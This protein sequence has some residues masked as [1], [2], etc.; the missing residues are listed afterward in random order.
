MLSSGAAT[1]EPLK[2][3]LEFDFRVGRSYVYSVSSSRYVKAEI[4]QPVFWQTDRQISKVVRRTDEGSF[5]IQTNMEK[6]R[7]KRNVVI[8]YFRVKYPTFQTEITRDGR[9]KIPP[10]QPFPQVR[11]VPIFPAYAVGEGDKWV[12]EDVSFY[13]GGLTQEVNA[14]WEYELIE[15]VRHNGYSC[16]HIEAIGTVNFEN[17]PV[18]LAFLGFYPDPL[19]KEP[20][21]FIGTLVPDS[22]VAIA[23]FLAG[24]K[25]L[26][27]DG[28]R[29]KDWWELPEL[30][31]YLPPEEE[32]TVEIERDGE[33]SEISFKTGS[34][35]LA[36]ASGSGTFKFDIYFGVNAGHIISMDG[37]TDNLTIH[38]VNEESQ[39]TKEITSS[40]HME[41][42]PE[43]N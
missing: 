25:I 8:A 17:E 36:T 19:S 1:D 37:R 43:G 21:A 29:I 15:F 6:E 12:V 40:V 38:L 10:R 34:I 41:F 13:P 26:R 33:K 5:L 14:D 27:I 23:G 42:L 35:E 32:I 3:K 9:M 7:Q 2:V 22:P 4:S 30:L 31:P 39:E 28:V 18:T 20:G 16:A 11:N 24:D